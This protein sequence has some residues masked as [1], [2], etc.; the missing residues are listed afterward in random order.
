M[1]QARHYLDGVDSDEALAVIVHKGL[2]AHGVEAIP[3]HVVHG[4]MPLP[5][6]LQALL[7]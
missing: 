5:L 4:L 2:E 3:Q 1:C 7:C 6:L